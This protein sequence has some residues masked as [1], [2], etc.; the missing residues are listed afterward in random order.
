MI[1]HNFPDFQCPDSEKLLLGTERE[2]Q[3]SL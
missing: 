2:H 1:S 3:H